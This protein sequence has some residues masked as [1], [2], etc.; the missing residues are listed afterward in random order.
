MV[1]R[2]MRKRPL[3]NAAERKFEEMAQSQGWQVSKRGWPD[4]TC[5]KDGQ[6]IAV[7]VKPQSTHNLSK[8]QYTVMAA[9]VKY[10][11]PCYYWAA[12]EEKFI[13]IE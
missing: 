13:Q 11:V 1:T 10:G 2:T 8:Y 5:F 4:F 9:L 7:E 6:F 12:E 3:R